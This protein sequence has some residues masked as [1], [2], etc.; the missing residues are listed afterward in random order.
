MNAYNTRNDVK[1]VC[2]LIWGFNV[3]CCLKCNNLTTNSIDVEISRMK[4]VIK[5]F[6]VLKSALNLRSNLLYKFDFEER[7]DK[8][9]PLS[10]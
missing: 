8:F 3:K 7:T 4:G 9:S 5:Y 2:I 10:V 6:A 1:S